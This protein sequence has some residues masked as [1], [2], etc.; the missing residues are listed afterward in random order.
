MKKDMIE[1][2]SERKGLCASTL[3]ATHCVSCTYLSKHK[4][5]LW[6]CVFLHNDR[7]GL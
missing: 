4:F 5:M 2:M 6:K 3:Y 1:N 7:M